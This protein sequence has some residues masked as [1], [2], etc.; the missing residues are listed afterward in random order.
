MKNLILI[1]LMG[2]SFL[3][4]VEHIHAQIFKKIG[5]KIE[6]KAGKVVDQALGNQHK[7]TTGRSSGSNSQI[8]TGP[9]K[10]L[11]TRDY[12]FKAGSEILFFDD[13]SKDTIREMASRWTSNGTGAVAKVDGFEG[14][15]LKLYDKNTYKIKELIRLPENFT[16]SF[17][18]LTLAETKEGI[19][20]NFG[21]DHQK[22]VQKYNSLAYRNPVNVEASFRFDLMKFT[23]NEVSPAK[24][25]ELKTD[26]SYFVNDVMK[27]NMRVRGDRM[28]IYIDQY[29]VLDTEMVDPKT[30][31]YFYLAVENKLN[32][33][34][35]Y[36]GN[37]RITAL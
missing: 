17:D 36:L 20:I 27:V 13:F 33:G 9:F 8:K 35:V 11:P 6:R 19:R 18:L 16:L 24:K 26:M 1:L 29:K 12:D 14:Q 34:E 15:W 21:F 23:S 10:T 7:D 4:S 30:K 3:F 31:K 28:S 5:D 22:G 32:R 25:S 37:F 2:A